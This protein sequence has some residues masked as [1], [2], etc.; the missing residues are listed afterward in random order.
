[1][2]ARSIGLCLGPLAFALAAVLLGAG[3]RFA[4]TV[5]AAARAGRAPDPAISLYPVAEDGLRSIA[6]I[7]AAA[8]VDRVKTSSSTSKTLA[9]A[10]PRLWGL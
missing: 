7:H 3:L 9:R 2:T 6:A 10:I 8:R 5:A 4:E 1:M